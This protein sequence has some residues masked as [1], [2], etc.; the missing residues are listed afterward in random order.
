MK[1]IK[2]VSF[3]ILVAF[4]S[5]SQT[6]SYK[7]RPA[8]GVS[9]LMKDFTTP[10]LIRATSF[11]DVLNNKKWTPLSKMTPGLTVTYSTGLTEN[12][13][14]SASLHGS[15]VDYPF[16]A[17]T[18]AAAGQDKFLME[19]DLAKLNFKL[20]SDKYFCVPYIVTGLGVSMYDLKYFSAYFPLGSG[21]QF[22]LGSETFLHINYTHNLSVTDLHTE[23]FA[24]N[25]GFASPLQ[26]KAEPKVVVAPPPPPP[27]PVVEDIEKDSDLSLIHI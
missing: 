18:A 23:N 5:F 17:N 1:K 20:L 13:D 3:A 14:Y 8:L 27:A 9:F 7:K 24:Y 21:L 26:D 25:I 19:L 4:A 6:T 16:K 2:L 12:I 22:N 10:A 11:S 15:F